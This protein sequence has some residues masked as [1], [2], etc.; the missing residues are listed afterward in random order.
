MKLTPDMKE[1][2][3]IISEVLEADEKY[4][5]DLGA[6]GSSDRRVIIRKHMAERS[7]ETLRWWYN[8]RFTS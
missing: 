8:S 5:R 4:R 6:F 1:A 7:M 3:I 2:K